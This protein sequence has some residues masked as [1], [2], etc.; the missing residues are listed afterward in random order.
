LEKKKY[1]ELYLQM[2]QLCHRDLENPYELPFPQNQNS[3]KWKVQ[4]QCTKISVF[5]KEQYLKYL[6]KTIQ[7]AMTHKLKYEGINV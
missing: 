7:F 5:S 4:D 3:T 6:K 1:Y 2:T